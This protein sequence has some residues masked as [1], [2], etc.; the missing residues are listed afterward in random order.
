MICSFDRYAQREK[1]DTHFVGRADKVGVL[2]FVTAYA[3]NK[4]GVLLH[5]H[6]V[7]SRLSTLIFILTIKTIISI[8]KLMNFTWDE[9][10]R[11]ANRQKHVLDF[12]DA[13]QVFAGHTLTRPDA[14]FPYGEARFSTVGLLRGEVVM[15]A[16]TETEN[17]IHIISMRKAE[18]HEREYYFASL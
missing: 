13:C 6:P 14:R 12:I 4:V 2:V 16:H 5:L 9:T 18:R 1:K 7:S 15:I 3:Q 8:V 11:Q 17:T 10:K